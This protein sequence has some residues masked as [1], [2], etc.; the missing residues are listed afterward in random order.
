MGSMTGLENRLLLVR[1]AIFAATALACSTAWCAQEA[2]PPETP[3]L[4]TPR[5]PG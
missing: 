1:A 2:T 3:G 4:F 5:K